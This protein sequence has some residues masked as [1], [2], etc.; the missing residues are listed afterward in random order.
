MLQAM[1]GIDGTSRVDE[2]VSAHPSTA[3]AF[4]ARRMHCVGC[5]IARF[6]SIADTARLYGL[7]LEPLLGELRTLAG[8]DDG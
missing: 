6:E 3:R 5:E 4:I 8:H 7:N 2:V 1:A